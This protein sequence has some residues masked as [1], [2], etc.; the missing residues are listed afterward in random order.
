MRILATTLAL[1]LCAS[2]AHAAPAALADLA[3]KFE[4]Q[5]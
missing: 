2:V 3:K 4:D 1:A 5:M